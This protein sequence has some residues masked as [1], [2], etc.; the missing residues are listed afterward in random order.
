MATA[1]AVIAKG[2]I[3]WG[4]DQAGPVGAL[5]TDGE[6]LWVVGQGRYGQAIAERAWELFEPGESVEALQ[7][8]SGRVVSSYTTVTAPTLSDETAGAVAERLAVD[9]GMRAVQLP[10]RSPQRAAG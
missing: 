1:S 4:A 7:R 2:S 5:V 9:F 10:V 6:R 3:A 8:I